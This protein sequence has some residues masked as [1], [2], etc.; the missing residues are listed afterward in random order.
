MPWGQPPVSRFPKMLRMS[1]L[2]RGVFGIARGLPPGT[3][4]D[5]AATR[6]NMVANKYVEKQGEKEHVKQ[7]ELRG[8]RTEGPPPEQKDVGDRNRACS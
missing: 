4:L 7:M 3:F 2:T 8:R 1:D 5:M 6:E